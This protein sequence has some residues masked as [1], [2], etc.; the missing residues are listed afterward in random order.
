ML[1]LGRLRVLAEVAARGSLSAAADALGY[2][3]SAVS[4]QIATLEREAGVE[5]LERHARGVALTDAGEVLVDHAARL[6]AGE[7]AAR[8]EL[9]A[10]VRGER[11]RV[12]MGW[13]TTAGAALMPRALA[14]FLA[15]HA[16]VELLL[17]ESDPD[18]AAEALRAGDLDLA[19]IYQFELDDDP[20]PDLSQTPLIDD[21]AYI[22]V[23]A[24]HPL[25][26]RA[27]LSLSDFRDEP[28]VQGVRAG[29]TLTA[30]PTACRAAGFEPRIVF[31]TDDHSVV[32]GLV[33]AGVGV[34]LL[35]HIAV[36]TIR[37]DIAIK[38]VNGRGLQRAVRLAFAPRRAPS[39]LAAAMADELN[40][41]AARVSA[42]ANSRLASVSTTPVH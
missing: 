41:A 27:R 33:A 17:T 26:S 40:D 9:T 3:P 32:Q 11:G 34:A 18:A 30:L 20:A 29:V 37:P 1:H 31:R 22:G 15:E 24:G 10:L 8:S 5:L 21:P 23:A 36:P 16:G 12:R 25:A 14:R 35:P 13:F 38:R 28:W 42:E 19:L 2:T 4:Q 39:P 6:L 7:Q